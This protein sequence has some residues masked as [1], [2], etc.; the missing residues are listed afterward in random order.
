M[1]QLIIDQEFRDIIPPLTDN[2]FEQLKANVMEDGC[3]DSLVTWNEIIIDGHNRYKICTE[4][5]IDFSV[6]E[7]FFDCRE[8]A[9]IWICQNQRGRRNITEGQKTYLMGKEQ[10]AT[11][12]KRG[13]DRKSKY[14]SG[15]LIPS[16]K[17]AQIVADKYGVGYGTVIRSE[18]FAKGIDAISLQSPEAKQK[19][20][21]GEAKISKS[22]VREIIQKPHEEVK[23]MAQEIAQGIFISQRTPKTR[24]ASKEH[25]DME[26]KLLAFT[27]EPDPIVTADSKGDTLAINIET[28]AKYINSM[29]PSQ[30]TADQLSSPIKEK[31]M[32]SIATIENIMISLKKIL[33]ETTSNE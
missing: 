8:D 19:I 5:N 31:I 2:E 16:G 25:R 12:N 29:I 1:Q 22:E 30:E 33:K 17:T 27:S 28:Y 32:T 21:S 23:K 15:T 9:I 11:K 10:E 4:N 3:R 20:L 18:E 24:S 26:A 7:K 6:I 13:G 14:Q